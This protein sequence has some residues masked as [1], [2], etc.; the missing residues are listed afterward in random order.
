MISGLLLLRWD[1]P[2]IFWFLSIVSPVVLLIMI[3]FLPETG[4]RLV[5]DGSIR[6]TRANTPFIP[7]LRPR[8]IQTTKKAN[9]LHEKVAK[10][11]TPLSVLALLKN[12]ATLAV[13]LCY[14]IYYAVHSCLQASLS[15]IFVD[16]YHL[17]GLAAGLVYIPFGI[18]C[19]MA[20]IV[21]GEYSLSTKYL[22]ETCSIGLKAPQGKF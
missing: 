3:L 16:I 5:G 20:S 12:R 8:L 13:V 6:T 11:A 19:S 1:W 21:A 18:A 10:L 9:Q 7:I 4:R 15:T 17:P 14:G 22:C 2:S